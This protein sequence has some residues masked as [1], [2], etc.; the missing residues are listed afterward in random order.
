MYRTGSITGEPTPLNLVSGSFVGAQPVS[1]LFFLPIRII[2]TATEITAS[3]NT[4]GDIE[5]PIRFKF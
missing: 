4:G 3:L 2:D 5:V 1:N